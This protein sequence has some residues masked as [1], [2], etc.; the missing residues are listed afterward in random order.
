MTEV[1]TVI[2]LSAGAFVG[3]NL[4]NLILLVALFSRYRSHTKVVTAG[5]FSGMLLI[6][7]SCFLIAELGDVIPVAWLGMLGIIPIMIGLRALFQL[8]RPGQTT[9]KPRFTMVDDRKAIFATVLMTQLANGADSIITFSLILA[10]T[11]DTLGLPILV[12]FLTMSGV[13]AGLAYYSLNHRRVSETLDR[14]GNYLTPF[15]LI[16]V[17]IYILSNTATDLVAG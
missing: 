12:T 16:F 1:L 4:D 8:F 13:L 9:D 3:T 14:F 10:D 15:I 6:A 2:A 7:A 11:K 17:G 5:Y